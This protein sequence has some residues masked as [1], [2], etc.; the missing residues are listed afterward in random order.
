MTAGYY[1]SQHY[2]MTA[3]LTTTLSCWHCLYNV[4]NAA[5][6]PHN[7]NVNNIA[8]Q[9]AHGLNKPGLLSFGWLYYYDIRS[10]A[11]H[12]RVTVLKAFNN[13]S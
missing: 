10:A 11:R 1:A 7:D 4:I 9:A 13:N 12:D 2:Y 8:V 3:L 6:R 5:L